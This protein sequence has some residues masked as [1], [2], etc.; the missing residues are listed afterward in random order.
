MFRLVNTGMPISALMMPIPVASDIETQ[1]KSRFAHLHSTLLPQV[2][3]RRNRRRLASPLHG[4]LTPGRISVGRLPLGKTGVSLSLTES[5]QNSLPSAVS[6]S[7]GNRSAPSLWPFD[8]S[9]WGDDPPFLNPL[10]LQMVLAHPPLSLAS[11]IKRPRQEC[12]QVFG[13]EIFKVCR[14]SLVDILFSAC[15]L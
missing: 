5:S 14:T 3:G 4:T 15:W 6:R 2:T 8:R 10:L 9:S 7:G 13:Y 11:F 1:H 12:I